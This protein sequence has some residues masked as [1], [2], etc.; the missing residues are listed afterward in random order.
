LAVLHILICCGSQNALEILW[1]GKRLASSWSELG[2]S[3]VIA[4]VSWYL[5]II[6]VCFC[7]L[8]YNLE[9]CTC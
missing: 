5:F 7:C 1:G 2:S 9:S 4:N 3:S 8:G 6:F